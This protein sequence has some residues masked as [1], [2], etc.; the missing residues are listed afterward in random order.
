MIEGLRTYGRRLLQQRRAYAHSVATD[1]VFPFLD[2][3]FT[4]AFIPGIALAAL[5]NYAIVGPMTLAVLPLNILISSIMYR[6]QRQS[7]KHAGLRVRQH[8]VGFVVYLL[9]FQLIMSPVSVAG[10]LQ[11]VFHATRR[12]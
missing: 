10:Y 3:A 6:R 12:W 8:A 9:G 7:F 1:I 11:E 5:G 4:F 2:V